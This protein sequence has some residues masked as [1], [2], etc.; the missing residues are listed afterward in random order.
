MGVNRG[1]FPAPAEPENW[2]DGTIPIFP[3]WVKDNDWHN[4]LYYSASKNETDKAGNG[5]LTCSDNPDLTVKASSAANAPVKSAAAVL[6]TPGRPRAGKMRS[7]LQT[8]ALND[9]MNDAYDAY[10]EDPLNNNKAS[11]YGNGTEHASST[12]YPK[13]IADDACDTV[14]QPSS[15]AYD[16]DRLWV[17]PPETPQSMCTRVGLALVD[18]TPC[19][20]PN[21]ANKA[22]TVCTN[23]AAKLQQC[24]T[25][26]AS[27]AT[28]TTTPPCRNDSSS[29]QCPPARTALLACSAP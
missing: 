4:Q 14:V 21:N 3:Q 18:N 27:A 28:V 2:G 7:Y 26:C 17:I 19:K 10:F 13:K 22:K 24:S 20:D 29:S 15:K 6:L 12:S 5:C 25:A 8:A 16:R 1:R 23:M 9:P 11:C